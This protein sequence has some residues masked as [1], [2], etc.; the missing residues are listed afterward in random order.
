MPLQIVTEGILVEKSV[1][2]WAAFSKLVENHLHHYT[3]SRDIEREAARLYSLD[4]PE[5]QLRHFIRRV[6]TWG[7]YAGIGVRVLN[8]NPFTKIRTCFRNA[9]AH[10]EADTP[11]VENALREINHIRGLGR[12]SFASKH[13]RFL[14][15]EVC[16][17]LDSIISS[18]LRY[19]FTPSGY[20]EL[21]D[22]CAKIARTL[23]ANRVFNP[24]NRHNERWF[25][26]DVEM[27]VFAHINKL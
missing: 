2:P 27:A 18:R 12:P 25:A 22:D 17:V 20:K 19:G 26:A 14:K 7:G 16:P 13:L 23:Q 21:S 10:L 8:Q 5:D 6:C 9:V 11:D 1:V 24:M 15:P 4:F 3:Q